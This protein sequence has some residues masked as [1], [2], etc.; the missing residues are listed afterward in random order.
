MNTNNWR[1]KQNVEDSGREMAN[2]DLT[3]GFNNNYATLKNSSGIPQV[4]N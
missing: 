1:K 4:Q 3:V 2:V